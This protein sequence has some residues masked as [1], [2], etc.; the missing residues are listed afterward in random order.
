MRNKK[1]QVPPQ[2]LAIGGLILF[3]IF[4]LPAL[5]NAITSVSCQNEKGEVSNL[6]GL[7][8]SC[9]NSNADLQNSLNN[10]L[11]EL[12]KSQSDCADKVTNVT[13][14]YELKLQENH[15]I[16]IFEQKFRIFLLILFI[17]LSLL[18]I[19]IGIKVNKK[20]EKI[21]FILKCLIWLAYFIILTVAYQD[22]FRAFFGF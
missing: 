16:L 17:P 3:V 12:N 11:S 20:R 1:A 10:C 21:F 22:F 7:L 19:N 14:E 4:V 6:N 15:L 13:N 8:A 18:S 2:A 5:L 9:Q